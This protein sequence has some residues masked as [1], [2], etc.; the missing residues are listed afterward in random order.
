VNHH[1]RM[2]HGSAEPPALD[3]VVT[4]N[5]AAHR[6]EAHI[7]GELVGLTTYLLIDD[8]VVFTH[9]EVYPKW[10]GHGV[11][12]SLARGALDDVVTQGKL[13]TPKCPF[14]VDY[15]RQ[16]PAY[17]EHVDEHHRAALAADVDSPAGSEGR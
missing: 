6:Y 11:G 4:D 8:R 2:T 3:V 12:S 5:H 1:G 9:A 10:E 7:D 14:I 17:L 13:I 16:H 15:V